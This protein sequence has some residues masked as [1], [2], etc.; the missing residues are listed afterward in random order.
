VELCLTVP[1]RLSNLLPHLSFLMKPLV[2]ALRGGP[3]L[4]SL[5][6]RTLE[7]CVENLMA[8]YLDPI[9]APIID[10]LMEALWAQLK[11]VPHNHMHS[12]TTMR[13]LGKLGG[14]NRRFLTHPPSLQYK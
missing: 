9:M 6:L 2:A 4:V 14:R 1:A 3:D 11:P 8:D 13:I 12:H 5:G 10:D 7:L